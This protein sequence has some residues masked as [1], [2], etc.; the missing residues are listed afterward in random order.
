MGL[1]RPQPGQGREKGGKTLQN[2]PE[3]AKTGANRDKSEQVK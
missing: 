1:L 3:R 2:G